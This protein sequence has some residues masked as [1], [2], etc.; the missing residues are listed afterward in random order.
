MRLLAYAIAASIATIVFAANSRRSEVLSGLI[1][2]PDDGIIIRD[3]QG[4]VNDPVDRELARGPGRE[5]QRAA[6][7]A[8]FQRVFK[9]R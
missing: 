7:A 8:R 1:I 2:P 4:R 3:T 9:D 5:A 6:R